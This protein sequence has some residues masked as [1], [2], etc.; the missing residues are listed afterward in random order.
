MKMTTYPIPDK[1]FDASM[2]NNIW[3][4][5]PALISSEARSY[6]TENNITA[7]ESDK[8]R[9]TVLGIDPQIAF[10]S[11][12]GSLFVTGA[13]GDIVRAAQFIYRNLGK[14]TSLAFSLDTHTL[15]QV[16]HPAYWE[17]ENGEQPEPLTVISSKEIR[18]AKWR[19]RRNPDLAERYCEILESQGKKSLLIW[20]FHALKG[21]MSA[22]LHPMIMEAAMFHSLVRDAEYRMEQKGEEAKT[23]SYS[24]FEPDVHRIDELDVGE[25]NK[26][27]FDYI[28]THD[29]VYVYGEASSHCVMESLT[30]IQREI[31]KTDPS[32]MSRIY[33][34]KD[35]MSPVPKAGEGELDFPAIAD[36]AIREFREAGMNIVRSDAII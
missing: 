7:A 21:G 35:A 4:E 28:M 19:A 6:K 22:T 16:F 18:S 20:P 24:V 23:E 2:V 5:R 1:I 3:V 36:I 34:I 13:D 14:I 25:F 9:I 29:R 11:P 15:F 27:F 10:T 26:E 30:S 17:D 32:L 12:Q 8:L 31:E 33:I